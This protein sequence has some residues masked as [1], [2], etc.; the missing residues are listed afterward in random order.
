[1]NK[2]F[3]IYLDLIRFIAAL[4][5]YQSHSNLRWLSTEI[6]P[7]RNFG[8]SAVVVF[9]LLSGFVIAHVTHEK[10]KHWI[11]YAA[12]RLSRVYSV[13]VPAV[14]ATLLLDFVG[15]HF[16][17]D[18]YGYPFDKFFIRTTA[19]L[20]LLNEWW[21]I[22]IT[23]FSN[24]PFWSICYE[25]WY[26]VAF[27]ILTFLPRHLGILS[28]TLLA[29]FLGPKILL[30]A[31][32]WGA[33]VLLYKMTRLRT[34]SM[35]QSWILVIGSWVGLAM[36]F[37]IDVPGIWS[38]YF[39]ALVGQKWYEEFNFSKFF[40]ADYI[41]GLL[42]FANFAGMKKTSQSLP[43]FF[44]RIEKP[45][46]IVAK[47]TFS[48][49]LFHQ[50]LLLFWGAVFPGDPSYSEYWWR[51]TLLV[52]VSVVIVGQFTENQRHVMKRGISRH[53]VRIHTLV[54]KE[55]PKLHVGAQ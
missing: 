9:F 21:F 23:S 48:L 51:T 2:S 3:S 44:I 35:R 43:L 28:L 55:S 10:E 38:K 31:P 7:A 17:P 33:G 19:S 52:M 1:M 20:L 42:I 24:V 11:D 13:V 45:V 5:V 32:L 37:V 27:G 41:L 36:F 29:A 12:S 14:F 15:R 8:H 16:N 34:L 39:I 50:P 47:Y 30:L 4:L 6:L 25:G 26:Y 49:Y 54:F 40:G 53:L 18:V 22:A 46:R